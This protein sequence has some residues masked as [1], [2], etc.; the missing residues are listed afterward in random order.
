MAILL[1][2]ADYSVEF[3]PVIIV[4]SLNSLKDPRPLEKKSGVYLINSGLHPSF[5][6]GQTGRNLSV[7]IGGHKTAF[8]TGKFHK[9]AIA[10][11]CNILGHDINL[12]TG[13][14]S[15]HSEN[16]S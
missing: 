2:R 16:S 6:I 4:E 15:H 11:H 7:W 3:Y 13:K 14:L 9:S 1:R 8:N 10:D 12:I 5:Y